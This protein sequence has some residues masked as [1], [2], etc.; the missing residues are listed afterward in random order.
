MDINLWYLISNYMLKESALDCTF[1]VY[2]K[3]GT[4]LKFPQLNKNSILLSGQ[5]I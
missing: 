5:C 3:I 4:L 2:S 1:T